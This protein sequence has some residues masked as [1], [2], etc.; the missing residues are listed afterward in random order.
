[1][2]SA[3][4]LFAHEGMPLM[5][6][7]THSIGTGILLVVLGAGASAAPASLDDA[8]SL[9]AFID[10]VV[11]PL[12]ATNNS[13]SGTVAIARNGDVIF[14][15]GYGFEDV[16]KQIPVVADQ[17]LFRPGSTSK[18]FTW[19]SVMQLVEKGKLD[20]DTDVNTY[21]KSFQIRDTFKQ[22]ITLRRI[23]THTAGFEDGG[24]G[25]LIIEDPNKAIALREAMKRYQPERVNPPGTHTAYSN[26]ATAL[27][28]LIVENVSGEPFV[29]YVRNHILTPLRME[30]SSF[31]EPLPGSLAEH[32]AKSYAVKNG[33]YVEKPFEIVAN[34]APAGA[35][36]ATSTDMVRFGQAI[37]NGGELDGQ[38]IL[39]SDTLDLMLTRAFSHDDRL[40][41]MALGFYEEDVN[42]VRLVGHGGDTEWF[43]S[44]IGVDKLHDLTF[45]VSF[46]GTG[47]SAVRSAFTP[48]FYNEFFPRPEMRPTPPQGFAKR[49]GKYAGTYA[50]WRSNFS[51]IEKAAGLMSAVKVA[52]TRD[53]T[54]LVSFGGSAKQ[55]VEVD[56]NLF[57]ELDA[58]FPLIAGIS[59]ALVAFQQNDHGEITGFV[60]DGLPFMSLRRLP[61][62]AT[63][64]VNLTLLGLSLL[65]FL[66]VVAGRW[67]Q[68]VAIRQRVPADRA[69]INA[70]VGASAANLLV[71]VTGAIVLSIVKDQLFNEIP[72]LF[73]LWLVVPIIATVAGLY[74]AYRAVV[75]WRQG[76]LSGTWARMR[77]TIVTL[78][79]LFMCWFYYYWNILGFQYR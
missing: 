49:G 40:M 34:F 75:V 9:E 31:V 57:R 65:V 20:L 71:V 2:L 48:A 66:G 60:M 39:K 44:Y 46:G 42:G 28:G 62:Y 38:R 10:G 51:T 63:P 37:L 11:K 26:Y 79:A 59:P 33:R 3:S 21:L 23:M 41:G 53:D 69:A 6:A 17:T 64:A 14:A 30:H 15:K 36:S 61:F 29:D 24:L 72:L 5:R 7:F 56:K 74:I 1:M 54:L 77:F 18:L 13:P 76:A 16:D 52:P 67:Y 78:C 12:M 73:K 50:F 8:A 45:F 70:E 22:P 4:R 25:Y 68:R 55:Y 43:H 35:L 58:G 47:G 27:A 32:M 19:V